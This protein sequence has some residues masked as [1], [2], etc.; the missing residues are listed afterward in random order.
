VAAP[1][2]G[3]GGQLILLARDDSGV[4]TVPNRVTRRNGHER[5]TYL[6]W[7]DGQTLRGCWVRDHAHIRARFDDMD[8][9][10]IPVGEFRSTEVADYQNLSLD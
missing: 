2:Q 3:F 8:D 9:R 4:G 10:R 1:D 6:T 5:F 7:G